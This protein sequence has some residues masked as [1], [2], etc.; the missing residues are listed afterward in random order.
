[1]SKN[2]MVFV[3]DNG[4][5]GEYR[6][7]LPY[8]MAAFKD[9]DFKV[10]K[11][12]KGDGAEKIQEGIMHSDNILIPRLSDNKF[13]EVMKSLQQEGKRVIVDYDDD[14]FNISPLSPHYQEF[15][16]EQ[17]KFNLDGELVDLWED[18]KNI[19]IQSNRETMDT[20][21]KGIESADMVTVTTEILAETYRKY[22]DNVK[23]VPN[24]IDLKI[25]NKLPLI[26]R[27]SI[28]IGWSGG[29]S[30]YEDMCLLTSVLPVIMK[31]YPQ[32]TLVLVGHKFDGMLKGLP[33]D[34][35]EFHSW[36]PTPAHPYRQAI[37][38]FD[39]GVIP[40]LDTEFNR[41]KSAIKWVE[42]SA[43]KVPCVASHV[44]PY[45]EVATENNGIY[46]ENEPDAWIKGISMLVED[47]LLRRRIGNAA[48]EDVKEN[49]DIN[50]QWKQW[51]DLYKEAA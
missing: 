30:H 15:G 25:W 22:N 36:V 39:I 8:K 23:V 51:V 4:A 47:E 16:T 43:L 19:N 1:M 14:M 20:I 33:K 49:F 46:V 29:S 10:T 41:S 48:Y 32:V 50:T 9:R 34:R 6:V 21:K 26:N 38:D 44:S 45:K 42:C 3:R 12:E 37:L 35:I 17:V 31:K 40:L 7:N 18:G 5:C 2:L 24:C 27:S 13:V 11:I 28:R